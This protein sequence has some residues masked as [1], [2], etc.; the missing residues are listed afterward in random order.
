M[1]AEVNKEKVRV[2]AGK[3]RFAKFLLVAGVLLL[4][5]WLGLKGWRLARLAISLQSYQA[6]AEALTEHGLIQVDP[7]QTE[8]LVMKLRRDVVA[9][10]GELR[11]FVP[12]ATRLRFLPRIGP[13]LG[14][15]EAL[16][17]MAV[18]G[19]EA[20]AYAVRA[21]KPAL[22]LLQ[23]NSDRSESLLAQLLPVLE[24][25]QA[26]IL[27]ASAAL[28]RTVEA[29]QRIESFEDYPWRVRSILERVDGKLY[30]ADQFKLL[31]VL[32]ALMAIDG[33][34]NYLL[35]AQ[36][37]DEAR[38]TG[39]FLTG[40]GLIAVEG[41][42]ITNLTFQD[43]NVIDDWRN[44][45]YDFPPEPLYELMGLEL[46]L[47]RDANFWP[48][49]PTSAENAIRLYEYGQDGA[50]QIDGVIAI[51][52]KFVAMLLAVTGPVHVK[53]LETSLSSSNALA[54]FRDSWGPGED[55]AIADWIP[56]RKEFLGPLAQAL[57]AKLLG[58]FAS[59]DP[60][61]LAETMHLAAQQKRLQIYAR[62]PAVAR[63]L[64]QIGWDGRQEIPASG[65]YFMFVDTNVG[66]NKVNA[67]VA[68]AYRYDVEL[69]D[70]G[71]AVAQLTVSYS[72]NGTPEL[73]PCDQ[74]FPYSEGITYNSLMDLCFWNYLRLY[75][76]DGTILLESSRHTLRS[77][78]APV[79]PIWFE[80][81]DAQLTRDERGATMITNRFVLPPGEQLVSQYRYQ[82]P[83]VVQGDD[84]AVYR[85]TVQRQASVDDLALNVQITLPPGAVVESTSPGADISG[86]HVTFEQNLVADTVFQVTFR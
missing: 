25:G 65:D 8:A 49:F 13:L 86:R 59:L 76:P 68:T 10:D 20:A 17:D 56:E 75:V 54:T 53:E 40:A 39:G 55:Q 67:L 84:P 85:L 45:P 14:D 23:N 79:T 2:K 50:P 71:T 66:Y 11:P 3:V 61:F 37:E 70:D 30:L 4:L 24:A 48:D 73:A 46:F 33:S 1:S 77:G 34:K 43:A 29:R 72:H 47:F 42:D 22:T 63:V 5:A 41:G 78:S 64:Q 31:S 80:A 12:L 74:V 62:D 18:D 83:A 16:L 81:S 52:Q 32:P 7:Q 36:N 19:S 27:A 60:L 35:L 82:L 28:D 44:K 6:Q 69:T 58:D 26:D 9:L 57:H 38:A 51:D 15:S 21:L